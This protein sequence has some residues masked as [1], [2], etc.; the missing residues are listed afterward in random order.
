ME[1]TN[2][3]GANENPSNPEPTTKIVYIDRQIALVK[4][5]NSKYSW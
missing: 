3:L 2:F 4:N 1:V 5:A